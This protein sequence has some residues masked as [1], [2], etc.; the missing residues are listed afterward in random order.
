MARSR[1]VPAGSAD[2][3]SRAEQSTGQSVGTGRQALLSRVVDHL[4]TDGSSDLTLRGLGQAVGTSHRMLIYHFGG[5][6]GLVAA[7]VQE[8]E[9]RQRAALEDLALDPRLTLVELTE[10]LWRRLRADELRSMERLFFQLYGRSLVRHAPELADSLVLP[11][12]DMV[13]KLLVARHVDP[14]TARAHA[15]LGTAVARGLLLDLL[16][17]G[18][19]AGADAAMDLYLGH[20]RALE[21]SLLPGA[22]SAAGELA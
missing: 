15:R 22:T 9:A 21:Q 8:V 12:L 19:E 14:A 2:G 7:A 16:A 11:W 17:T 3:A 1:T 4:S 10:R 18:D 13:E 5:L 6:D 20:V